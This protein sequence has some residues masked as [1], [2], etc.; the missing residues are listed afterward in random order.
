M[1]VCEVPGAQ[2]YYEIIGRGPLLVTVP[3]ATGSA[4]TFRP[5]AARLADQA[6]VLIY[7]RRGF[8]RSPLDTPWDTPPDGPRDTPPPNPAQPEAR[9]DT[10][11]DDVQR[12]VAQVGV[13]SA[14]VLGSSSGAIVALHALTRH[15]D[16]VGAALAFEPPA[17]RLLPDGEQWL[18]FFADAYDTYR[19][20]GAQAAL[21]QFRERSFAETDRQLMG[22][23]QPAAGSDKHGAPA[24]VLYWM[25]HELRQYPAAHLDL[26]A[27]AARAD[28]VWPLAG[29]ASHGYP[30]YQA[31]QALGRLTGREVTELPGG[32]VGY[33]AAP[34]EAAPPLRELLRALPT[35]G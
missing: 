17:M 7:D 14:A 11:A 19:R 8:S 4:E 15:P 30:C 6:S 12:L 35:P 32:H 27:L 33:L 26:D 9:L 22:R 16:A 29:Q 10:D 1:S 20:E 13:P 23:A 18:E 5:I 28:R 25:E 21:R 24:D 2:L 31:A 3:G 34:D